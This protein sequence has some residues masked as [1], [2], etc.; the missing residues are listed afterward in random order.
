MNMKNFIKY[1]F[2]AVV[3]CFCSCSEGDLK[4]EKNG[5]TY[6]FITIDIDGCEYL[7][8]ANRFGHKGNCKN[9]IHNCR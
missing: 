2:I 9:K 1:G 5:H 3:I 8:Y 7:I 6:D 4:A